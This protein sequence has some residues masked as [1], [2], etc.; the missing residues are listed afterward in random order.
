M[1]VVDP[2]G[3]VGAG[4]LRQEAG[5]AAVDV[6]VGSEVAVGEVGEVDAVVED[7]PEGAV[8]VAE[9]IA[10]MLGLGEDAGLSNMGV[11]P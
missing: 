3:V 4:E 8:G 7:R 2:D 9:V 1:V 6:L 5:E 11:C 10:L